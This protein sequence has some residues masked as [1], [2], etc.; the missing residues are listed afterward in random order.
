MYGCEYDCECEYVLVRVWLWLC[1]CIILTRRCRSAHY[2]R[3]ICTAVGYGDRGGG[4]V[5]RFRR[6]KRGGSA[7]TSKVRNKDLKK[8]GEGKLENYQRVEQE[9]LWENVLKTFDQWLF[10]PFEQGQYVWTNIYGLYAHLHHD[11]EDGDEWPHELTDLKSHQPCRMIEGGLV[12]KDDGMPVPPYLSTVN[13]KI[14]YLSLWLKK[15]L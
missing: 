2:L 11:Y 14:Q 12:S 15:N 7:S 13:N 6:R 1:L 8:E 5:I 4:Q 9:R 3:R 10:V